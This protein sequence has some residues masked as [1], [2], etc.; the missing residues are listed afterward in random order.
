MLDIDQYMENANAM[1]H[2]YENNEGGTESNEGVHCP[3]CGYFEEESYVLGEAG[4]Y[5][6]G[7]NDFSCGECGKD[8]HVETRIEYTWVSKQLEES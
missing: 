7:D 2:K 8:F 6:E 4:L 3:H 5:A 1:R